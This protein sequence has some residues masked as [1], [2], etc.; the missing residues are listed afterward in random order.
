M[1]VSSCALLSN[2]AVTGYQQREEVSC[3]DVPSGVALDWGQFLP[4]GCCANLAVLGTPVG[5]TLWTWWTHVLLFSQRFRPFR[6]IVG[7]TVM[8]CVWTS[9][10]SQIL[11]WRHN[12]KFQAH[13]ALFDTSVKLG[14][15][16]AVTITIIFRYSAKLEMHQ[17]PWQPLFIRIHKLSLFLPV[18]Q[19]F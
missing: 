10:F 12:L 17:V 2:R 7:G 13:S 8:W 6:W 4:T 5:Q 9:R 18:F 19:L 1:L 11:V 3:S 14:M 15:L 16:I